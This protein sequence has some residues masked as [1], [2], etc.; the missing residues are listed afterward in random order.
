MNS[1]RRLIRAAMV[2]D[3]ETVAEA[4]GAIL[5]DGEN[6]ILAAGAPEVIGVPEDAEVVDL[7]RSIILPALVNAHAHLDLTHLGSWERPRSFVEWISR[8]R[9]ARATSD[10]EIAESVRRGIELSRSGGVALVGDIAGAGSQVPAEVMREM[11]MAGVSFLEVFGIGTGERKAIDFVWE[12]HGAVASRKKREVELDPPPVRIGIEPH[13]PYSCSPE[14]YRA[15]RETN[16]PLAT[17]LAESL[18]EVEFTTRGTGTFKSLLQMVGVWD[19]SCA[20]P[21]ASPVARVL[22]AIGEDRPIVAAHL[23]YVDDRDLDRLAQSRVSVAYCPRASEYFGHP[24]DGAWGAHRYRDMLAR[25]INVALG[26]DSIICLGEAGR[27]TVLDDMRFLYVRDGTNPRT[28]LAMATVNG[29]KALGFE[30]NLVTL[31]A[32]RKAGIIAIDLDEPRFDRDPLT[33]IMLSDRRP[34]W[35]AGGPSTISRNSQVALA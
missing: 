6:D 15:A 19:V 21:G 13:A 10:E 26:T 2:V 4:P 32:G 12:L 22:D 29:A 5:L 34:R 27:M 33:S 31:R 23:N 24:Q 25:G 18:E 35:I 1:R 9:A 14:V 28:L 16:L 8:V 11:G 7:P 20:K 17:H 3:G 30:P